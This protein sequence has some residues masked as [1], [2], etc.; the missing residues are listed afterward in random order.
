MFDI[1]E[2]LSAELGSTK[3]VWLSTVAAGSPAE[4]SVPDMAATEGLMQVIGRMSPLGAVMAMKGLDK[5][6]TW[7]R[8]AFAL[9]ILEV[10]GGLGVSE[11]SFGCDD[12]GRGFCLLELVDTSCGL[13]VMKFSL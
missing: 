3:I 10:K 11:V 5:G 4:I 9:S 8:L 13:R 7:L 1:C 12:P 6:G 2:S